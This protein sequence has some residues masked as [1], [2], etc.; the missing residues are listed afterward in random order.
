VSKS[1]YVV[2]AWGKV[3]AITRLPGG[4]FL[5]K[6]NIKNHHGLVAGVHTKTGEAITLATADEIL[7]VLRPTPTPP[8]PTRDADGQENT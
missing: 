6:A 4:D 5:V 3:N 1:L 2:D 7:A 8:A